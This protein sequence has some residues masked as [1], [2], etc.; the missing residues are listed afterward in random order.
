M[1]KIDLSK[2]IGILANIGVIAGIMFLAI[3]LRQN[4]EL[5]GAEQRFNRLSI[6]TGS[7]TLLA[8]NE[9]LASAVARFNDE[10]VPLKELDLTP[11]ERVQVRGYFNRVLR[12]QQWTFLELSQEEQPI[13]EWQKLAQQRGWRVSWERQKDAFHPDFVRF[14]VANIIDQES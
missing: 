2:S 6:A 5:M 13:V 14:V 1:K 12:N 10:T 8:E 4:N 3:E 7:T 11:G 9:G